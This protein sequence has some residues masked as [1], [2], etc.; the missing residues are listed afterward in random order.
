MQTGKMW[1][2]KTLTYTLHTALRQMVDES[3]VNQEELADACDISKGSVTNYLKG[4]TVPKWTTV[5]MW[6]DACGFD[7][8]DDKLRELWDMARRFGCVYGS[9]P[10]QLSLLGSERPGDVARRG[11]RGM[12]ADHVIDPTRAGKN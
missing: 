1:G 9:I 6:A 2:M 3:G 5:R 10:G 8:E 7:P 4:R 12:F 11:G